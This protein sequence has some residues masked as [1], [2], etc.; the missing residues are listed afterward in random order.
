[1]KTLS[2]KAESQTRLLPAEQ[3]DIYRHEICEKLDPEKRGALGQYLTPLPV[4]TFM[5]SLFGDPPT[6]IVLLDPGAGTG[7]L[8]AAFVQEMI[9]RRVKPHSVQAECYELEPLMADYL[10]STLKECAHISESR[11]GHFSGVVTQTDFIEW[12]V[13]Q[14]RSKD[15]LFEEPIPQF[16]HCIMNPP[17][18]KIR[19]DSH[20]RTL[21]RQIGIETGN[22][23]S[24]FLAIA[25][26]LLFPGGELVAI[27]PRS[28]CNGP[29]FRS[30]RNLLL[31]SMAIHHL[32][33]FEHRNKAF[34]DDEVL[35]ENIILHAV[36]ASEQSRVVIT[37]SSGADLE[38]ITHREVP[39]SSVVKPSD[40]D[41]FIHIAT[42]GLDQMVV[43][44]ISM[45]SN[46]LADIGIEVCTGPV[47]DFRLR[48]DIRQAVEEDA[49][50]LIYPGHFSGN[51]VEWPN[52]EGKKPN[53]IYESEKSSRWL[54]ENGS[55]VVTRR[56]SAKEESRRIVAALHEP[57]RIQ[58]RKIGFEN[59]LNVFHHKK[60][61][62]ES[63]VAKGLAIF[64]NS[65]LL[66]LYFRQFSGHT[67]VNATDLRMLHYPDLNTLRRLGEHV[68]G[69]FP[70]Q[71]E[72]DRILDEEL[73]KM[74]VQNNQNP[75]LIR[76]RTKEALSILKALGLPKGQLNDRSALTLL[77]LVDLKPATSWK[78]A[79]QPLMGITPIM[80]YIRDHYGREYKPNT[81]E[82]IRRQTVHQFVDA[83]IAVSN[84]DEPN[85]PT[86]SPKW[87]YQITPD[88]LELI[89]TFGTKSWDAK[90]VA[91]HKE[92]VTLAEQYAKERD[93][94]MIPLVINGD[95]ELALTPGK[96]SQLIKEII[97]EF[98]PRYAPG[99][100]VLYVGDTGSKMGHFD[101]EAFRRLGLVFDSHG[102]FPDVVLYLGSKNWLLLI[103]SV[104]SHGSVDAKRHAE[105][106]SL[107][108]DS[109]AGIVYVTAFPDRQTMGK[110]LGDIS[111][112]TEVWVADVPS[113]LI[114][115]DGERFLGPYKEKD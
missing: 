54:M 25:I 59:H 30:F 66:D 55:Y 82:T 13:E 80:D 103:E 41:R 77:A 60:E 14:L 76:R 1:M 16:T 114:H 67:Q 81:R 5:A 115:F 75:V 56:F 51:Y 35:Q 69:I 9:S 49:C 70:E 26:K 27:V 62:L 4:A 61:G 40:P 58:G 105:L 43:D 90:L 34:K 68:T 39:F 2:L 31:E 17:Y 32:H 102:K 50:P 48:D 104:T 65:T 29:Y 109:T 20:H 22:L 42:S 113:H 98:G 72:V 6:D 38:D 85:R 89:R 83:G 12:G 53:S 33:I 73:D 88:T 47:V 52:L 36:K 101:E 45:F 7:T 11:G 106:A 111:W 37:S 57:E 8:M 93:M 108:K 94:Q 71:E 23:Y 100:E 84:P 28:F 18:K 44:R 99:A 64:L 97:T 87:C 91:Y 74:A 10:E 110:Y 19:G 24:G 63:G 92:R 21:L 3:A 95:K 46:T 86:N 96:H 15:T 79:G 107:F 78:K 112:E